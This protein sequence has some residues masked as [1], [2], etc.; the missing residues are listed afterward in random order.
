MA[1]QEIPKPRIILELQEDGSY[2][3]ISFI[4]GAQVRET[5]QPGLLEFQ[6]RD[7]LAQQANRHRNAAERKLRADAAKADQL[8]RKVWSVSA[9]SRGQGEAFANRV[10]GP[11]AVDRRSNPS[12]KDVKFN[13]IDLL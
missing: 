1:D 10:I 3:I 4:N 6:V 11:I 12:A 7:A 9:A 5:I 8:H 13:L 2:S